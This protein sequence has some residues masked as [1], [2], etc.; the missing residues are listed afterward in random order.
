MKTISFPAE[1]ADDFKALLKK[2]IGAAPEGGSLTI[3]EVRTSIKVLDILD[4]ADGEKV[5]LEDADHAAVK[6]RVTSTKWKV[7]T[8]DVVAFFDAIDKPTDAVTS[9]E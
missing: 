6:R 3:E 4:K 8:P 7:A 5:T 2:I 1:K 9:A